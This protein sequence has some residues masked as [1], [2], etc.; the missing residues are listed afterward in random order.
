MGRLRL[1]YV[2]EHSILRRELEN[3]KSMAT[4]LLRLATLLTPIVRGG[5][6]VLPNAVDSTDDS[7][8]CHYDFAPTSEDLVSLHVSFRSNWIT[9]VVGKRSS[10][11]V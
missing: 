1:K 11:C 6:Y 3:S 8:R 2:R 10:V 9:A 7:F 5:K 4:A